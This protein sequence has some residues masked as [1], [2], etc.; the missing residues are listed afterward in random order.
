[1]AF[2][3]GKNL[4]FAHHLKED[5]LTLQEQKSSAV[6]YSAPVILSAGKTEVKR[7]VNQIFS[8]KDTEELNRLHQELTNEVVKR[9][10]V[11]ETK[12]LCLSYAN[13]ALEALKLF[14]NSEAKQALVNIANSCTVQV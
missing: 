13:R 9:E 3:F 11:S 2:Q 14:P 6:L 1:M 5:L 8:E 7:L 10:V 12:G 4:A